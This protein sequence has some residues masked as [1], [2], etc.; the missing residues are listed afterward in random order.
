MRFD[1]A[2]PGG[3]NLGGLCPEGHGFFCTAGQLT[4]ENA[5]DKGPDVD[6]VIVNVVFDFI[7]SASKD[8]PLIVY[9]KVGSPSACCV[10]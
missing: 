10:L 3:I 6:T 8:A 7:L 4:A 2:M 9:F 5:P 1:S